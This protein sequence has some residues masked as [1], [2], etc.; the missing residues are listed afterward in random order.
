MACR[1]LGLP[2][3]AKEVTKEVDQAP[4]VTYYKKI[5]L[6]PWYLKRAFI[7]RN[8]TS[9]T[10]CKKQRSHFVTLVFK[11]P[12]AP[13]FLSLLQRGM[14]TLPSSSYDTWSA[15]YLRKKRKYNTSHLSLYKYCL[16][17]NIS[18]K[19]ISIPWPPSSCN[20]HRCSFVCAEEGDVGNSNECP[21][22]TGPELY[23]RALLRDLRGSIKVSK[24]DTS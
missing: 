7:K 1:H 13:G 17:W 11:C 23:D 3:F 10:Q 8:A 15:A 4:K 18:W 22:F 12:H 5:I 20:L 19:S 21:P 14:N 24:A 16:C 6:W 2:S 9:K